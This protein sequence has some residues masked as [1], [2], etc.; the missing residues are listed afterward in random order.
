[1]PKASTS[2]SK[3]TYTHWLIKA[4]P[5]TRIEKGVD[6]K[7]SID[8]LEE[9]K[10]SSWE[11]VRNHEAKKYLK[12]EMKLDQ[13]CLFYAS[14]CK[15]PGITGL[16]KVVKEGYPDHNAWDPKHPYYD[17]KSKPEN[18]TWFMVDVEFVSRLPHLVPLSL[19]QHLAKLD[20]PPDSLSSYLTTSHLAAIADSA[21]IKRGR[22]SVQPASE[23][24]FEAVKLLGEKGEFQEILEEIKKGK[25][26]GKGKG[27]V[28]VEKEDQ[29][30]EEEEKKPVTRKRKVKEEEVEEELHRDEEEEEEAKPSVKKKGKSSIKSRGGRLGVGGGEDAKS[31]K[32]LAA[33]D[34]VEAVDCRGDDQ[35]PCT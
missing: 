13:L 7:F 27:K 8:D 22:L 3:P 24:F 30:A 15:V 29:G 31:R 35:D 26:K 1:M 33:G 16:A 4:E 18:P 17:P 21:L 19:L 14:N 5:E 25:T 10:V 28:K 12:Q 2:S 9:C 34:E 6:V 20:S 23:D 11:G 32:Q